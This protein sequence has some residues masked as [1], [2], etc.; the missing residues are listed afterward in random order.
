LQEKIASLKI[1]FRNCPI[2]QMLVD[3]LTKALP[4]PKH[5]FCVE[6]IGFT[7]PNPKV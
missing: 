2:E 4:K 3:V 1:E 7:I 6:V 5:Q